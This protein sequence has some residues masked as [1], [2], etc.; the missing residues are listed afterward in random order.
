MKHHT[1]RVIGQP[2]CGPISRVLRATD[3]CSYKQV[4]ISPPCL[5]RSPCMQAPPWPPHSE[6]GAGHQIA[7]APQLSDDHITYTKRINLGS[8]AEIH[9]G[10]LVFS[11]QVIEA[12]SPQDPRT[13]SNMDKPYLYVMTFT[14]VEQHVHGK[15]RTA[16]RRSFGSS[17]I[18]MCSYSC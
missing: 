1:K 18:G 15:D 17:P 9:S 6:K 13:L 4:G 12:S 2:K 16:Q 7:H 8:V 10:R 5:R 14:H 3:L 11:V